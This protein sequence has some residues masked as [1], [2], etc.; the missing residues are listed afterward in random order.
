MERYNFCGQKNLLNELGI[1]LLTYKHILLVK[2][3]NSEE[4]SK[5][6]KRMCHDH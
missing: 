6:H 2:A 3:A 5:T 4:S 1:M